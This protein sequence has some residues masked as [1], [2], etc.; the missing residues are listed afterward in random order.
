MTIDQNVKSEHL[1]PNGKPR[2]KRTARART[3][4]S[5][6]TSGPQANTRRAPTTSRAGRRWTT[7]GSA[8]AC[9]NSD[10]D[11]QRHQ[12]QFIK[13]MAEQALSKDVVT[14]PVKLDKVLRAAGE[15]LIFNGKGHSVVDWGLALKDVRPEQHRR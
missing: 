3:T 7:S 4:A 6:R 5:T 11:R 15:S 14:N 13:A 1:Q 8:T 2:P 9:P 10:Y 12:Q